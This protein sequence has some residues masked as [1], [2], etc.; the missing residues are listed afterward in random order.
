MS[1]TPTRY[2]HVSGDQRPPRLR[3]TACSGLLMANGGVNC[4]RVRRQR[5]PKGVSRQPTSSALPDGGG[6][7]TRVLMAD[8]K[9]VVMVDLRPAAGEP[10]EEL[11]LLKQHDTRWALAWVPDP[12]SW[13]YTLNRITWIPAT[14][15]FVKY[16]YHLP[17]VQV[18]ERSDAR[19]YMRG[20]VK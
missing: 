6:A 10:L 7:F 3:D 16:A 20:T 17:Q 14:P 9:A 1:V 2:W 11:H 8:G 15:R 4:I 12:S 18:W 5:S 19:Y 13:D